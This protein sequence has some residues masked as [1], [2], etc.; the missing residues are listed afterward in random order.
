MHE[1]QRTI[2]TSTL[3]PVSYSG[4]LHQHTT[5]S[6]LVYFVLVT[7]KRCHQA[8]SVWLPAAAD[9]PTTWLVVTAKWKAVTMGRDGGGEVEMETQHKWPPEARYGSLWRRSSDFRLPDQI[10][11][12]WHCNGKK[13]GIQYRL[14][15]RAWSHEVCRVLAINKWRLPLA[16]KTHHRIRAL[17][18]FWWHYIGWSVTCVV[19]HVWGDT[20]KNRS[21][22]YGYQMHDHVRARTIHVGCCMRCFMLCLSLSRLREK[23]MF[24]KWRWQRKLT[25][26]WW[27]S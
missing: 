9:Y 17:V 27:C 5:T 2:H 24:G 8:S 16:S 11:A 20:Y 4:V 6:S 10:S 14:R 25:S 12:A 3:F 22:G 7:I 21:C 1:M 15:K 26:A 13:G 19:R 23:V 18:D